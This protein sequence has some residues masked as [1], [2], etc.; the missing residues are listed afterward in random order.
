MSGTGAARDTLERGSEG[1]ERRGEGMKP[2]GERGE[3]DIIEKG[4]KGKGAERR[5]GKRGEGREARG[6]ERERKHAKGGGTVKGLPVRRARS[7]QYCKRLQ[8]RGST[9]S[10]T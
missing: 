4:R 3:E 8:A 6:K 9:D 2:Q 10:K 5:R 7:T 1:K